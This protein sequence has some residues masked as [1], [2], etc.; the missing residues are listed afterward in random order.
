M[1][2]PKYL[3]QYNEMILK[4]KNDFDML[5]ELASNVKS[6]EF[7][8]H[9]RKLLRIIRRFEDGLLA[10]SYS[11]GRENF[12]TSLSDKFMSKIREEYPEIDYC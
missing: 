1:A 5:K 10:R 7:L 8:A 6:E 9:Q 3:K 2:Q 12:T 4:Y 11:T